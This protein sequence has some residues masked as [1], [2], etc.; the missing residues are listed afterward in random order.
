MEAIK[1]FYENHPSNDGKMFMTNTYEPM[2]RLFD[3]GFANPGFTGKQSE[4]LALIKAG[5][6]DQNGLPRWKTPASKAFYTRALLWFLLHYNKTKN[7]KKVD[8]AL[9]SYTIEKTESKVVPENI[10][11]EDIEAA[12]IAH[13][14]SGSMEDIFIKVFQEMPSRLD[15]YDIKLDNFYAAKNYS[16]ETGKLIMRDY[17]KTSQLH[18][19]KK[20]RLSPELQAL[21]TA[22]LAENPR[23]NLIQFSNSDLSKAIRNLLKKSGFPNTS[24]NTLRHSVASKPGMTPDDRAVLAKTMAHRGE[25]NLKY[26]RPPPTT[27]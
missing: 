26:K 5:N 4:F 1:T 24:M 15:Y 22:S 19:E 23:E 8:L 16:T 20:I 3:L 9:T 21:I 27:K 25:T 14:G 2:R 13:F 11:I 10:P 6:P 18:G 12:I 7:V 17:T